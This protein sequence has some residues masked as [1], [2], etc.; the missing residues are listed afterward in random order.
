MLIDGASINL[1]PL[2]QP[3]A[4][5]VG[6]PGAPP[7]PPPKLIAAFALA[8]RVALPEA[9]SALQ[10]DRL[11]LLCHPLAEAAEAAHSAEAVTAAPLVQTIKPKLGAQ[12]LVQSLEPSTN[13]R[14]CLRTLDSRGR[15]RSVSPWLRAATVARPV[16]RDR[17]DMFGTA[18]GECK[19]CTGCRGY[20]RREM[21]QRSNIVNDTTSF[22]CGECGC[23]AHCHVEIKQGHPD[24]PRSAQA[25][26]RGEE[27]LGEALGIDGMHVGALSKPADEAPPLTEE[28]AAQ[29][30]AAFERRFAQ[31]EAEVGW[32]QLEA[33][34]KLWAVSDL[35][36]ESAENLA[37]INS[38]PDVLADDALVVAGDVCTELSA[39]R[40][41]LTVL[42]SRFKHVF[43]I[44]GNHELWLTPQDTSDGLT[45]SL[46]KFAAILELV[47]AVGAHVSLREPKGAR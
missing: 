29:A 3:A 42:V 15:I 47:T 13:V 9:E 27:E 32:R 22:D 1:G 12:A 11:E 30:R 31:W 5:E 41:A 6:P 40:G 44:V 36:V 14:L 16:A 20:H 21:S 35:H 23:G 2:L 17:I 38:L 7:L 33:P 46:D 45:D 26:A 18:R 4:W 19:S 10:G 43:Y 25:A 34:R 39:L 37:W 28:E 24:I 8:L